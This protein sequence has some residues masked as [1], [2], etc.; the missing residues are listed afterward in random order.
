M[1]LEKS[2]G[3]DQQNRLYFVNNTSIFTDYSVINRFDI[4]SDHRLLRTTLRI[5]LQNK[6]RKLMFNR[7]M[8]IDYQKLET[9]KSEFQLSLSNRFKLIEPLDGTSLSDMN[10]H[11]TEV[12]LT[13]AKEVGGVKK[14]SKQS[15][16][17]EKMKQLMHQRREWKHKASTRKQ[18]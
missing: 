10:D 15:K 12:L 13:S 4:G 6:R 8:L 5:N 17:S 14:H 11:I 16:I 3:Y 2:K 9:R 18:Y 7:P 1:D